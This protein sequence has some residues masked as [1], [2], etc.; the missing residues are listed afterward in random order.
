LILLVGAQGLSRSHSVNGL[1][2][3]RSLNATI[4]AKRHFAALATRQ[5]GP[6]TSS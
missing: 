1:E 6:P 2:W 3:Q 5:T 4:G